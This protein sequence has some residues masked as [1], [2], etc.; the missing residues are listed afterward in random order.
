MRWKVAWTARHDTEVR[1]LEGAAQSKGETMKIRNVAASALFLFAAS[2]AA[3][4]QSG[5]YSPPPGGEKGQTVT[6]SLMGVADK[7]AGGKAVLACNLAE[8]KHGIEVTATKLRPG[9][10][11][12]IWLSKMDENMK[13]SSEIRADNP[14]KRTRADKN[15]K[16][17]FKGSLKECPTGAY[18]MVEIRFHADGKPA[19]VKGAACA[20]AGKIPME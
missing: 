8:T 15:G 6:V 7:D 12:S 10:V 5:S 2:F 1:S 18:N 17:S 13:V 14:K 4:A 11:Y 9:G 19:N 16:L 3:F 20:V